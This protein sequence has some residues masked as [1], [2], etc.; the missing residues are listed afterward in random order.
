MKKMID[1]PFNIK[2]SKQAIVFIGIQASG[3]STF[4]KNL[5]YEHGYVHINLDT[6]RTRK[7]EEM[8]LNECFNQKASFVIDN[9]NPTIEDR[10]KYILKAKQYE[11]EVIGVFFQS[12]LKD[13]IARNENRGTSL[14]AHA[15]AY[16]Q[17]RL[18]IPEY[19]EGF[20]KL[21]FVK[22]NETGFEI[23]NWKI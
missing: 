19:T 22:L 21:F 15:I 2:S 11:Y 12:I 6:L 16:T 10:K 3:K 4:Y 17:K 18:Q 14:P 5:L 13:C 23:T 9:T 1:L 8:L 20:D 7:K